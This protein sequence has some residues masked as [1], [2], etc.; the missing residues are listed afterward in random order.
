LVR[1]L[2]DW[3]QKLFA[4]IDAARQRRFAYGV[5]DCCVFAADCVMAQTGV[6]PM[7]GIRGYRGEDAAQEIIN[8][9]GSLSKAAR[10]VLGRPYRGRKGQAKRGDV[11]LG[12]ILDEWAVGVCLG[13][14][15][16]FATISQ[17]GLVFVPMA[18][19]E[20]RLAWDI[21]KVSNG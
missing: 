21:E 15:A 20:V 16:A 7:A 12:R 9:F 17:K 11:V 4:V 13:Q 8:E 2:D 14:V 1:R 18:R 10:A 3:D 6:D 19:A 5:H